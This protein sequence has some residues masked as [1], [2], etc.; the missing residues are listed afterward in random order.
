MQILVS[1]VVA[2]AVMA[3]LVVGVSLTGATL[4]NA[5]ANTGLPGPV[6]SGMIP[7]VAYLLLWALIFGAALGTLGGV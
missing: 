6:K 3:A 2:V 4:S 5:A 1:L 7:R